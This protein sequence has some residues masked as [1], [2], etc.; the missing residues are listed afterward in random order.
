MSKKEKP[1]ASVDNIGKLAS[2]VF[3][4]GCG[5][6]PGDYCGSRK[7]VAVLNNC[8]GVPCYLLDGVSHRVFRAEHVDVYRGQGR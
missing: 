8:L 5:F 3:K 1:V 7:I 2:V 6:K 4:R